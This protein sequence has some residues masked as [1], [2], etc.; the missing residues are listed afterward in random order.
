LGGKRV[1]APR[2]RKK[3]G[4]RSFHFQ[5]GGGL[6]KNG[7]SSKTLNASK[8]EEFWKEQWRGGRKPR[9]SAAPERENRSAFRR[10]K[11]TIPEGA[12]YKPK[13]VIAGMRKRK[14]EIKKELVGWQSHGREKHR[15]SE[16]KRRSSVMTA[17]K[18]ANN[19][20][21]QKGKKRRKK[22]RDT[23]AKEGGGNMQWDW[24]RAERT[25]SSIKLGS[26]GR[27]EKGKRVKGIPCFCEEG[28]RENS[29]H[30]DRKPGK[31]G[32]TRKEC[33]FHT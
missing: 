27:S 32:T 33:R 29:H 31:N 17:K 4:G 12:F 1:G 23:T 5:W 30:M 2:R 6:S 28:A 24:G 22:P 18:K 11:W 21:Y 15:R 13:K 10:R 8:G 26:D 20:Q 7:P 9:R 19:R 16:N 25:R 3:G 14:E